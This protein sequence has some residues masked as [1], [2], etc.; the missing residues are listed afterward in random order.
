MVL[1]GMNRIINIKKYYTCKEHLDKKF[2]SGRKSRLKAETKEE[3]LKWKEETRTLLKKVIGLDKMETCE[4]NPETLEVIRLENGITREK[5]VIQVEPDVYMPFYILIPPVIKTDEIQCF[6]ALPGH[7]GAGKYS[8]AGCYE[9]PAVADKIKEFNYD[10]GMQLALLGYV[11]LCPDIRGFGERREEALQTDDESAF[12]NS[13]C[14]HLSHMAEPLGQTVTGMNTWDMMRLLDYLKKRNEWKYDKVGCVGFSGGGMLTLWLSALDDRIQQAIISGYLYGYKDSLL[15]L[16]GNCSC[17]YI[18]HLWEYVDMGDIGA[19]L[20]P[21]QVMIQSCRDDHLNG[22]RGLINVYEQ[23]EIMKKAYRL[24][25]AEEN[26]KHDI[27]E[28]GH[29]FH[30]EVFPLFFHC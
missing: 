10:Y 17:N 22:P 20:A 2:D 18:P 1:S 12:I 25:G 30:N 5:V 3:Y 28:G 8:I 27:R 11:V 19:L 29:R 24:F 13:T 23:L 16:N 26:I 4:L 21:R 7:S 6:L 9:I 14:F 15:T